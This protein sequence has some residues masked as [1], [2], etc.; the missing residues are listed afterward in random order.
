[1]VGDCDSPIARRRAMQIRRLITAEQNDGSTFVEVHEVAPDDFAGSI[2][3]WGWDELP[4]LPLSPQQVAGAYVSKGIFGAPGSI[5]VNLIGFPP[6]DA[7][8]SDFDQT[9]ASLDLGTGGGMVPG[10]GGEGMH[11]TDSIDLCV[12]LSGEVT[13]EH[14]GDDTTVIARAGDVI[15]QNGAFHRWVNHGDETCTIVSI[16]SVAE[17]DPK[18][19]Q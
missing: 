3:I 14:P 4:R 1:V 12:V 10:E 11:R 17:R 13:I 6:A 18:V 16:V 7:P 5:R 19:G 9:L 2:N 8:P 15:V